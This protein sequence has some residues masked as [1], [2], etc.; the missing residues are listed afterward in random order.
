MMKESASPAEK[1]LALEMWKGELNAMPPN[2]FF[3]RSKGEYP[4]DFLIST[5]END[6]YKFVFSIMYT[7]H[8][9]YPACSDP[10][11]GPF[12]PGFDFNNAQ[13]QHVC[14]MRMVRMDKA[15]RQTK[16]WTLKDY[17][18][19]HSDYSEEHAERKNHP[20]EENHTEIAIHGDTAYFGAGFMA[21]AI[22]Y[23]VIVL[24][25][26]EWST[27]RL[28][29]LLLGRQAAVSA[30][31]GGSFTQMERMFTRIGNRVAKGTAKTSQHNKD[32]RKRA[33]RPRKR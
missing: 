24:L 2:K 16:Q 11:N 14:P 15:S 22:V 29:Y 18:A 8:M 27:R 20:V 30:A 25:R 4:A 7:L 6:K 19:V 12:P 33:V 1:K 10:L 17:C 26:L 13:M 5:Y 3:D 23:F 9:D 31:G 21:G 32:G 28:P